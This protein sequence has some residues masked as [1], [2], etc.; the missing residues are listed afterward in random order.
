MDDAVM[1]EAKLTAM[2]CNNNLKPNDAIFSADGKCRYVLQRTLVDV[3]R[4][5][6]EYRTLGVIMVN[7]SKAG[8]EVQDP[9]VRR[10]M[11]FA[12]SLGYER[13]LVG[14]KFAHVATDIDE[15]AHLQLA[16]A[17]GEWNDLYLSGIA[18]VAEQI[19]VAWGPLAKL[20]PRLRERWKAVVRILDER[21]KVPMCL[22]VAKDKHPRHPLMLPKDAA[23][24]P[25]PVPWFPNRHEAAA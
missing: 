1:R 16:E 7:P 14:N 8:A 4:P 2:H 17:T 10:V 18:H 20:P 21:G 13:V 6:S 15:L 25:W 24:V 12:T 9:T 5:S 11:G 3:G 23:L 19:I 22:G